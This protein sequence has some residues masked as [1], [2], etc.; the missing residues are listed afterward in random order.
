MAPDALW[1]PPLIETLIAVS[2]VYMAIENV[3]RKNFEHRWVIAFGFGLVHGFG[4]SFALRESLQFAGDHLLISLLSF[5]VGVELGQ[6]L[7]LALI[8]PALILV[9]RHAIAER[10]GTIILSVIVAHTAWHWMIDRGSALSEFSAPE[11]NASTLAMLMRWLMAIIALGS[12]VWVVSL[13]Q[14]RLK[15]VRSDQ[16]PVTGSEEQV[17]RE[18]YQVTTDN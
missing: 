13:L 12:L 14:K 17:E 4:F 2:I 6:L 18:E 7:V 9:F 5:N 1:F 16:W 15:K 11:F 10:V 3:V 8:V